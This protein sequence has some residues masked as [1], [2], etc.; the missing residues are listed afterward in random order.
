MFLSF[1]SCELLHYYKNLNTLSKERAFAEFRYCHY[2]NIKFL[3]NWTIDNNNIGIPRNIKITK[4]KF[5]E[6]LQ[7]RGYWHWSFEI[8]RNSDVVIKKFQN[9]AEFRHRWHQNFKLSQNF[10]VLEFCEIPWNFAKIKPTF[11][12]CRLSRK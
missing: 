10:E 3:R 7:F 12:K 1:C 4:S 5:R 8:S 9:F 11:D 6:S 2:W